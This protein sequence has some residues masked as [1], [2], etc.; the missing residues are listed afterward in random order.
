MSAQ[1]GAAT[2]HVC[3]GK[4][5]ITVHLVHGTSNEPC[6]ECMSF[7]KPTN[8]LRLYRRKADNVYDI[9]GHLLVDNSRTHKPAVLQQCWTNLDT[10]EEEWR[11]VDVV[12][13]Q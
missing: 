12:E 3:K 6:E 10:G 5:Y 11:D 9:M 1:P 7:W 2:C 4:K 13:E 8:L